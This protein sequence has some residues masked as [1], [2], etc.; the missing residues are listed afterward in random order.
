MP[1][2]TVSYPLLSR[3]DGAFDQEL[4]IMDAEA[5]PAVKAPVSV[6]AESLPPFVTL[7]LPKEA[8]TVLDEAEYAGGAVGG[9]SLT[10]PLVCTR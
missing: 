9:E 5:C 8:V 2:D 1:F 7:L 6:G 3:F 4:P 10:F